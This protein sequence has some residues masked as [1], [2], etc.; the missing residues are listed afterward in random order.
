MPLYR[1]TRACSWA[2]TAPL[3]LNDSHVV[4]P[5]AATAMM[6]AMRLTIMALSMNA[7]HP[8]S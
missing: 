5:S 2:R 3:Y 6:V 1:S 7:A 4:M 8:R